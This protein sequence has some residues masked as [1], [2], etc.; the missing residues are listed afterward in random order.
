MNWNG[1][2][3]PESHHLFGPQRATVYKPFER[4]VNRGIYLAL[5]SCYYS[6]NDR[7]CILNHRVAPSLKK[8]YTVIRTVTPQHVPFPVS[9]MIAIQGFSDLQVDARR[10]VDGE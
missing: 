4:A 7:T 6:P 8:G 3:S 5:P 1:F 10:T 2:L 9:K